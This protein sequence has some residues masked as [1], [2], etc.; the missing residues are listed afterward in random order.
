M[1]TIEN[2]SLDQIIQNLGFADS[3]EFA[4][5]RLTILL[6]NWLAQNTLMPSQEIDFQGFIEQL[7]P[8]IRKGIYT[9]KPEMSAEERQKIEQISLYFSATWAEFIKQTL[10]QYLEELS[11]QSHVLICYFQKKYQEESPFTN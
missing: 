10:L 1:E 8:E 2:V 4:K 7:N 11:Y 6:K 3:H 9:N 5:I